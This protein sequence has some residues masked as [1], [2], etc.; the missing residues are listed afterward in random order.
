M[1]IR[2]KGE[3]GFFDFYII[4]LSKKLRDCGVF[5]PTS[6]ENL[7]YAQA[8]RNNWVKEGEKITKDMLARVEKEYNQEFKVPADE[9]ADEDI[10]ECF[11]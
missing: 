7:T 8:N 2:Y 6:A 3:I 9:L 11:P 5:G 4:P 1:L 10:T